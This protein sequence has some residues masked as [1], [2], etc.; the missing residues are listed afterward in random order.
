MNGAARAKIGPIPCMPLENILVSCMPLAPH[1]IDTK[2]YTYMS[3]NG[4]KGMS[5]KSDGIPG[6]FPRYGD[7]QFLDHVSTIYYLHYCNATST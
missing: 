4:T 2:K 7:G 6:I 1:V 3:L 5:I